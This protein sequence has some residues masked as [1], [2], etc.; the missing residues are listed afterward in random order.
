MG[1]GLRGLRLLVCSDSRLPSK[2]SVTM[3]MKYWSTNW[4]TGSKA[5]ITLNSQST[6]RF[7]EG[8]RLLQLHARHIIAQHVHKTKMHFHSNH[9]YT[10]MR[11]FYHTF[12]L[13][14]TLVYIHVTLFPPFENCVLTV[15]DKLDQRR[16][17]WLSH[18]CLL[19]VQGVPM[20]LRI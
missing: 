14:Y 19:S 16:A 4:E 11:L 13:L 2:L 12:I 1:A 7:T 9:A 5:Q 10:H 3:T 6:T 17:A 8:F 20:L 18:V 15:D